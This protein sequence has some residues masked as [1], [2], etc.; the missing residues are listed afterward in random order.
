MTFGEQTTKD[1]AFLQLDMAT[2]EYG[3]NFLDTAESFPFHQHP[4]QLD[5]QKALSGN[6]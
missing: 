6:G 4:V 3:I 5:E 1:N 2:K